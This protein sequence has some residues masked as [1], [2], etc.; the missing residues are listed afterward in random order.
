MY[1]LLS[2]AQTEKDALRTALKEMMD[3]LTYDKLLETEVSQANNLQTYLKTIPIP[4]GKCITI[5]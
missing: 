4:L 2:Q 5:G 3:S 1:D